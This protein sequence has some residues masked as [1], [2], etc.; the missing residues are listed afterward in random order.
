MKVARRIDISYD[1]RVGKPDLSATLL[2]D[3]EKGTSGWII[4]IKR[5]EETI[6]AEA[7]A[8]TVLALM[9]AEREFRSGTTGFYEVA[10]R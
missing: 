4:H 8:T 5:G 9:M 2:V 6:R 10:E 1:N 3:A 7:S